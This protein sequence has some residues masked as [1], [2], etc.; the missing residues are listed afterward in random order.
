MEWAL[1]DT[2]VASML[3][4]SRAARPE[5]EFYRPFLEGRTLALSFQSVAELLRLP[6]RNRWGTAKRRALDG[7]L[8][9]FVVLPY[10]IVLAETW[11]Q[12]M[13]EAERAGRRLE[14]GDAWIAATAVRR[15]LPLISHDGDFL[16]LPVSGLQV[17][18]ALTGTP[19]RS[20]HRP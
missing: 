20:G 1:L 13:V 10:D 2:S 16:D 18:S 5:L 4:P 12:V 11:A 19:K 9:R 7:F 8:R 17:I 6:L 14:V 3:L 15:A